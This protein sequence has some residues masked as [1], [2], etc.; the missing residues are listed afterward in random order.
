MTS[1]FVLSAILII[2]VIDKNVKQSRGKNLYCMLLESVYLLTEFSVIIALSEHDQSLTT[3]PKCSAFQQ[4][5]FLFPR[6]SCETLEMSYITSNKLPKL[7][8]Q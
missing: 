2:Q 7:I 5:Y 4:N 6:T 1:S 8:A 3:L